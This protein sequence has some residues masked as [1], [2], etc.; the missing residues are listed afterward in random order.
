LYTDWS[1]KQRSQQGR[2]V[3]TKNKTPTGKN[4][5]KKH[6]QPRT[7]KEVVNVTNTLAE[8]NKKKKKTGSKWKQSLFVWGL[9]LGEKGT[10][11]RTSGGRRALSKP[12]VGLG[13]AQ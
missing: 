2:A 6:P 8:V 11:K 10:K 9:E 1:S 13:A 3:R 7:S 4:R 12:L 5:S